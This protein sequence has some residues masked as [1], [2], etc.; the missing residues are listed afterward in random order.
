MIAL[1][2]K[3]DCT[4]CSACY[5]TCKF[6]AINMKQDGHGFAHPDIDS[7][8]CTGCGACVKV[9]PIISGSPSP[10]LK[11]KGFAAWSK[12]DAVRKL[13]S[14]GGI[15]T[16]LARYVI[17]KGG[18]VCGAT[19]DKDLSVKHIQIDKADEI[20]KLRGSKYVQSDTSKIFQEVK[21]RLNADKERLV[22]F[23]GTPCQVDGMKK[24]LKR[25][26]PNLLTVDLVC[27]GTP[28]PG[29]W[30]QY[31]NFQSIKNGSR[32]VDYQFREK[33]KSWTF[34]NS[35]LSFDNG[36][37]KE[38][39]WF[40]DMWLRIFLSNKGLRSSCYGCRYTSMKR[41]SDITLAD[42]WGYQ[43]E[44]SDDKK[45]D[46]GISLVLCNN[47]RGYEAFN[48][49]K[50][51]VVSFPRSLET[52]EK[53]Q[54]SLSSPWPKPNGTDEFW[55]DYTDLPFKD[56]LGKHYQTAHATDIGS[57]LAKIGLPR[58]GLFIRWNV[59]GKIKR[60]IKKIIKR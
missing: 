10:K 7:E 45:T 54:R 40:R 14:S 21:A 56:F 41:V 22:L 13:S 20:Y 44:G 59:V 11:Q 18:T 9:C 35:K 31:V 52:I 28:S 48:E 5:Q 38:Y 17:G 3:E 2:K 12:S 51:K 43:P 49:I 16:E 34:F 57:L 47:E 37:T 15:F 25:D 53:S 23:S 58:L 29:M 27:H 24:F 1:C 32:L 46:K 26:Y 60:A 50:E 33:K 6:G 8:L 42:F 19:L 39:D 30:Q 36:S 55:R 4:G